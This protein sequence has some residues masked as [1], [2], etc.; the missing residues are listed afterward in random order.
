MNR[1]TFRKLNL[2]T[3]GVL[4]VLY[5]IVVKWEL[6]CSRK[7]YKQFQQLAG[8]SFCLVFCFYFYRKRNIHEQ[9]TNIFNKIENKTIKRRRHRVVSTM[10][11]SLWMWNEIGLRKTL[12]H[13]TKCIPVLWFSIVYKPHYSSLQ[14]GPYLM[15][16]LTVTFSR[17]L[18]SPEELSR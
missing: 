5:L 9:G 6:Q 10:D 16:L 18:E 11:S 15:K 4:S 12:A 13:D 3:A 14:P 17:S 1:P 2:E 8:R 7:R